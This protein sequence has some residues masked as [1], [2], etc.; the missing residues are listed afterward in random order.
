MEDHDGL[1]KERNEAKALNDDSG[2]NTAHR[3][4]HDPWL[5][6]GLLLVTGYN[7]GY[8]VSF[9]NLILKPLGW[10]WGLIAM[11]FIAIL[12]LYANWLLAGFHIIDGQRFI[13]YRDLMGCLFGKKI[14]HMTWAL[15]VLNLLFA[16]MGFILLAGNSLK[17]IHAAFTSSPLRLQDYIIISGVICFLFAFIVPNMS[18]MGAWFA[19]SGFFTLIYV[20]TII[21]VSIKDGKSNIKKD[22]SVSRSNVEKVFNA[23]NAISAILFTNTSGML[24]EIQCTLHKPAVKNMR[25]ALYL[26][27][28][29]GLGIY[30]VITIIGYWAY[31]SHVS[32]YLPDQFS[33]PK[34]ASIIANSAIFFQTII[35]QNVFC[36]PIHEALDTRFLRLDQSLYSLDNVKRRLLLRGGLF[37]LNTFIAAMFPFLGDFVNLVGSFSLFPLTFIFPSM[38]FIKVQGRKAN[39][40]VKAW[41]WLNIIGFSFVTLVTTIAA[42]RL[43]VQN[44]KLYHLFADT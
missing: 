24:P 2:L 4:D 35:S 43:I 17:E 31:G 44:A 36:S 10:T 28:T 6:V 40:A 19:L 5:Q 27:F 34:W 39:S 41:H 18:S 29:L 30:Y 21:A 15:Q 13:R 33:G 12:S 9:S 1:Q 23:F 42:L 37:L 7:C 26:Q 22:Y 3:I 11:V 16:N 20:V 25:K 32:E 8:I 38:I 14:H